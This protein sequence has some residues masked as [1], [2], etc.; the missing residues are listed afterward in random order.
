MLIE[1][2]DRRGERHVVTIDDKAVAATFVD[3]AKS[4]VRLAR[5]GVYKASLDGRALT[6]KID[7]KAKTDTG[8]V[9][10]RLLRY[11]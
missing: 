2:I 8:P 6:F 1:R 5:G 7:A 11:P 9:V 3:L 10:G 4:K